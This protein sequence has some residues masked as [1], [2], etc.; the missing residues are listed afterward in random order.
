MN[1]SDETK[2]KRNDVLALFENK[3]NFVSCHNQK[4]SHLTEKFALE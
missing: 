1:R 4:S 3:G 2:I